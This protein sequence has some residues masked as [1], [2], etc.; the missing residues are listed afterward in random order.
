MPHASVQISSESYK[1]THDTH[2]ES[3][4]RLLVDSLS[5][6]RLVGSSVDVPVSVTSGQQTASCCGAH[7]KVGRARPPPSLSVSP[8]GQQTAS[9]CD[10]H[11]CSIKA[12][13][14]AEPPSSNTCGQQTASCCEEHACSFKA[15]THAEPPKFEATS[16]EIGGQDLFS[17]FSPCVKLNKRAM[18]RSLP[19]ALPPSH[20]SEDDDSLL[21]ETLVSV[22][23]SILV[24]S[25]DWR[26]L[27]ASLLQ[28]W[29]HFE[30]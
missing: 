8:S 15:S 6:L 14:H 13:T 17:F 11:A 18:L 24:C 29:P 3:P 25:P 1:R 30:L 19:Q 22:S 9:C 27:R 20:D 28:Q 5:C 26:F 7:A 12:S 21:V 4:G 10:E 23:F 16:R 2:V